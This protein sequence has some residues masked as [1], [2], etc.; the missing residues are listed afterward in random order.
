LKILIVGGGGREHALAWKLKQSPAVK[1]IVVS[2][3]NPGIA[4][5]AT[6]VPAPADVSG[7]IDIAEA[8]GITLTIVGPEAPLVAGIVDLF[9][10]RRL[11]IIGPTQAAARLEGSKIFAKEFFKRAGIPTAR[12]LQ[13]STNQDALSAIKNFSF[14]VVI[15][16][17]GLAAGKGVV[18]AQNETEAAQAIERLGPALVIEEFLEGE[19]VSFIGVS[20]G[21]LLLP[22]PPAQDHKRL[23]DGDQGPN[24]GGMGAYAD[25]RILTPA[26]SSDVM[27]R[28]MLPTLRQMKVEGAPFTGFLYAGLMMTAAGPKVLEFNVRLGDPETQAILHSFRGDFAAFLN[29][30]VQ[31]T[32]GVSAG[33][34]GGCSV[35]VTFAADGYPETPC[36]GDVITG[37]SAAQAT[38][39]TVFQAGTKLHGDDLVTSGGRV[40]GVTAGG[41]TLPAA[42]DAAYAAAAKIHFRGMHYRR[43]IAQKGLL[44][45]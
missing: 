22:L 7:Y 16:A 34:W 6:C 17:D 39:A 27:E 15:K 9:R 18:I 26:Q 24:T 20:N 11:L 36:L 25:P 35:C 10:R 8:H 31:G 23:S 1:E 41:D 45:W 32:G 28:I 2:P 14:P 5:L 19:E 37:I 44:R 4:S 29:M 30:V 43:D 40:L 21:A 33:A 13:V 3:G 42:I 12:S 38:G